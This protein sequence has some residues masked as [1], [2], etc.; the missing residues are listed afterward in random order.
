MLRGLNHPQDTV[1][2]HGFV[3]HVDVTFQHSVDG[4]EMVFAVDLDAVPPK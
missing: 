2:R 1:E 3:I 4:N